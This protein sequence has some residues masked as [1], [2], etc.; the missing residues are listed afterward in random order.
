[1]S[2][3]F[4]APE[5]SFLVPLRAELTGADKAMLKRLRER[6][7]YGARV[8]DLSPEDQAVAER[9]VALRLAYA[10]N[11]RGIRYIFLASGGR[12][13]FQATVREQ[14][15]AALGHKAVED[16]EKEALKREDYSTLYTLE[17]HVMPGRFMVTGGVLVGNGRGIWGAGIE[18]SQWTA[19]LVVNEDDGHFTL[20]QGG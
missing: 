2:S 3:S 6:A 9:L 7:A 19:Y 12:D 18:N 10:S 5:R 8:S 4:T 20:C 11:D 16:I 1:M 17:L 14:L 15:T 13:I